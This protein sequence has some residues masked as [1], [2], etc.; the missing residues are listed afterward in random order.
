MVAR[1]FALILSI[2][3][4]GFS[5]TLAIK[6]HLAVGDT[7]SVEISHVRSNSSRPDTTAK[8]KNINQV[9]VVETGP[10]GSLLEWVVGPVDYNDPSQEGN[11]IVTG[12]SKALDNMHLMVKL[13]PA[14]DFTGLQNEADAGKQLLTV[15]DQ[16]VKSVTAQAPEDQKAGLETVVRQMMQPG[17]LLSSATRDIQMYFNLHGV[18]VETGKPA[19]TTV[20]QANPISGD[21]TETKLRVT[22]ESPNHLAVVASYDPAAVQNAMNELISKA[23][24]GATAPRVEVQE[25]GQY[26]YAPASGLMQSVTYTRRV[27]AAMQVRTDE[28]QVSLLKSPSR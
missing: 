11:P 3:G 4:F 7:F 24:P 19:Q 16:V 8:S 20:H 9:R 10:N 27:R 26:V 13:G 12:A 25:N 28:W 5:Q 18:E 14:G 2:A 23:S 15:A 6:P 21:P 17:A 22:M 1:N